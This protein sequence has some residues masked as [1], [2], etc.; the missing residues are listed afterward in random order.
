MDAYA[1][2]LPSLRTGMDIK[3]GVELGFIK[4]VLL[5]PERDIAAAAIGKVQREHRAD[6][7]GEQPQIDVDLE[8]AALYQQLGADIEAYVPVEVVFAPRLELAEAH[9]VPVF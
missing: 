5:V 3:L 9:G 7:N 2:L 1:A 8:E 6:M 4:A